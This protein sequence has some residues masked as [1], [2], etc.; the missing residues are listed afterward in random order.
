MKRAFNVILVACALS[1][2]MPVPPDV[3][4]IRYAQALQARDA[5]PTKKITLEGKQWT[6]SKIGIVLLEPDSRVAFVSLAVARAQ[7]GKWPSVN[8]LNVR[9]GAW[10]IRQIDDCLLLQAQK[11]VEGI[12]REA[13]LTPDAYLS[14]DE[15]LVPMLAEI[16]ASFS[17]RKTVKPPFVPFISPK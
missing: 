17:N 7:T 6:L 5:P 11:G 10:K 4:A 8:E 16:E 12:I 2:C 15:K 9:D 3:E 13:V 14:V 1:G